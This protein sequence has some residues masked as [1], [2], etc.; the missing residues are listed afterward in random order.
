MKKKNLAG[1]VASIP[2][3][4]ANPTYSNPNDNETITS[5]KYENKNEDEGFWGSIIG[6]MTR[7][8][9]YCNT[10]V[11][12][13]LV[14]KKPIGQR[15]R[16][17]LKEKLKN[18]GGSIVDGMTRFSEYCNTPVDLP[19]DEK[20][21]SNI[22]EETQTPQIP[23]KMEQKKSPI[24]KPKLLYEIM[25]NDFP[26][27]KI[28]TNY[29]GTNKYLEWNALGTKIDGKEYFALS[30]NI[31]NKN[32]PAITLWIKDGNN[33]EVFADQHT[34]GIVDQAAQGNLTSAKELQNP[35]E[36][37]DKF[38]KYTSN[39]VDLIMSHPDKITDKRKE[40]QLNI[41]LK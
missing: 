41:H 26:E 33:Y 3:A 15:P 7:F 25:M 5:E 23:Q 20:Q 16:M 37:N 34:D 8:S 9:E 6:G 36:Q 1:I 2:L 29:P 18:I 40:L 21:E 31:S 19:Q 22:R 10:P 13:P 12:I 27:E 14:E 17:S 28:K 30:T 32:I 39:L 24:G 4:I 11:D 38:R 35:R